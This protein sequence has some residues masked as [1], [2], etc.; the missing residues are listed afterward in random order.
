[1]KTTKTT[2]EVKIRPFHVPDCVKTGPYGSNVLKLSEL[3][4]EILEQL[5]EDFTNSVF[6]KAGKERPSIKDRGPFLTYAEAKAALEIFD[7]EWV[8]QNASNLWNS[9]IKD[10]ISRRSNP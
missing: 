8:G 5:C 4:P 6:E 1:M 10:V 9:A 7:T 2:I 3:P